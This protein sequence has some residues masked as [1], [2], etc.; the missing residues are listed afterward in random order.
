MEPRVS[1]F[2]RQSMGYTGEGERERESPWTELLCLLS[3]RMSG[4]LMSLSQRELQAGPPG[5][6]GWS[7]ELEKNALMSQSC[8]QTFTVEATEGT[9]KVPKKERDLGKE[10]KAISRQRPSQTCFASLTS[11]LPFLSLGH[12]QVEVK[13]GRMRG[14]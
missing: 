6:Y 5:S 7:R 9:K 12:Q 4:R 8:F 10:C 11:H 1:V 13:L 3:R 14:R 2:P